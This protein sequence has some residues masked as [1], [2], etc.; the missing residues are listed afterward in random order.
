MPS[1]SPASTPAP[2]QPAAVT[3]AAASA[4]LSAGELALRAGDAAER[5]KD[6]EKALVQYRK[7]AG[8]D[9]PAAQARADRVAQQL[10]T[11]YSTAAQRAFL[12]QNLQGAIDGWT[13]VLRIDPANERAQ[14]ELKRSRELKGKVDK[15]PN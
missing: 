4:P 9:Q 5:A 12:G 6:L 13:Q 10:V 14:Q 11:R 3:P 2:P 15:L 7:A 1:P 8:L